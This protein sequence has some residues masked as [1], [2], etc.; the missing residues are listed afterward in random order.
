MDVKLNTFSDVQNSINQYEQQQADASAQQ[1]QGQAASVADTSQTQDAAADQNATSQNNDQQA[2]GD[3]Q[4]DAIV[5]SADYNLSSDESASATQQQNQTP[6]PT[7]QSFNWKDEIKK[8]DKAE[9]LKELGVSDFAIELNEHMVRGGKPVDYLDARAVDYNAVADDKL[10]KDSLKKQFPTFSSQQIDL[11]FSRKYSVSED[12]TDDEKAFAEL[13]LK[14]DAHT[15]RQQAI[16]E[17]QKYKLPENGIP[18][19]DEAYQQWKQQQETRTSFVEQRNNFYSSHEATKSLHESKKVTI[20]LGKDVPPFNFNIDRPELITESF[21]DGGKTWQ[22]LT[23]TQSGEPDVAKQQLISLFSVDPNKFMQTIFN[24][25]QQIGVRNKIVG[26]G[27]NAQRPQAK[28]LPVDG[29][30]PTYKTGTYGGGA[31]K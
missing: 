16:S 2:Q 7:A 3:N 4:S 6:A 20:S 10:V 19:T 5:S 15:V 8:L 18:Q 13:Q 27:Q 21:T 23:T 30:K 24:Y 25:G 1:D 14:A 11:Y 12:A 28:V 26:E 31:G 22:R 9:I 29:A 17:Q